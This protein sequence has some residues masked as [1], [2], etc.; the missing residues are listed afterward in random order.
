M[1]IKPSLTKNESASDY[2][3][4]YWRLLDRYDFEGA[5]VFL[6]SIFEEEG[7]QRKKGK[8][9]DFHYE[10]DPN[11][12]KNLSTHFQE[13]NSAF[14]FA[15]PL[16][17][18]IE[19]ILENL[20]ESLTEDHLL[21]HRFKPFNGFLFK[22]SD[23]E[24]CN[25]VMDSVHFEPSEETTSSAFGLNHEMIWDEDSYPPE[26]SSDYYDFIY[27][28]KKGKYPISFRGKK[29]KGNDLHVHTKLLLFSKM[30]GE[31]V[32]ALFSEER[33][34]KIPKVFPF[35]VLID[36]QD[37]YDYKGKPFLLEVI[38]PIELE[39]LKE[40]PHFSIYE[41]VSRTGAAASPSEEFLFALAYLEEPDLKEYKSLLELVN[42]HPEWKELLLQAGKQSLQRTNTVIGKP[43]WKRP[44]VNDEITDSDLN[45]A[46]IQNPG[47]KELDLSAFWKKVQLYPSSYF[48]RFFWQLADLNPDLHLETAKDFQK[49]IFLNSPQPLED[50]YEKALP[51]IQ[52]F[53]YTLV[54][55]Y[56]GIPNKH[57][58]ELRIPFENSLH[59]L[60]ELPHPGFK[61]RA[62]EI[63]TRLTLDDWESKTSPIL[64]NATEEYIKQIIGLVRCMPE[65]FPWFGD[66][67]DFIF[68]DRLT[69]L[70]KQ[71]KVVV[72]VL[73]DV[74]ER[75]NS[76]HYN[77]DVTL[78][79]APVFYEIGAEDIHPL[80]HELHKRNEFYMED[81]YAKWSKQ[82]PA[83]RWER[84]AEV[85]ENSSD[86]LN[87]SSTWESLLYDSLPGFQLYYENIE[88]RND[89]NS[90]FYAFLQ[91]LKDKPS[92]LLQRFALFYLESKKKSAK[93]NEENFFS[94][95]AE[96]TEILTLLKP[97]ISFT[98]ELQEVLELGISAKAVEAFAKSKENTEEILKQTLQEL[99]KNAF[100]LFL[101]TKTI[102]SKY[103][104]KNAMEELKTILPILW[105][106][107]Y[108]LNKTFFLF[109]LQS[110]QDWSR[111]SLEEI[112]AFYEK[113][114]KLFEKH[115]YTD[116]KFAGQLSSFRMDLFSKVLEEE[117]SEIVLSEQEKFLKEKS[118]EFKTL[119][120]LDTLS[121][122]K[123]ISHLRPG[124]SSLN[125]I[126]VSKLIKNSKQF[127]SSIFQAL[128]WE[129]E[130]SAI[131]PYLKLFYQDPF[132]KEKLYDHP[133]FLDHLSYFI[134]NYKDVASK[135]LAKNLF[136][137]LKEKKNSKP[138]VKAV[139][140]LENE[141]IIHCFLSVYWAFQN[142]DRLKELE[143]LTDQ[144][145]LKTDS[146]KPEYVLIA[147]NLG[148]I[149]IQNGN[150]EKAKDIFQNL[151]SMD[152]SR[153]DYQKDESALDMEK[154]LGPDINEQY[155]TIFRKYFAMAKFNAACLYSRL[156]DASEAV[157]HLR[158]AVQIE[159]EVY[160]RKKIL[161]E[162][163]FS[164]ISE[165]QTYQE[166]LNSLN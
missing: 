30:I 128:E 153:F 105:N 40:N 143:E 57:R 101:K 35:Y 165:H 96:V 145:L 86:S 134:R 71:A 129:T 27:D 141:T 60:Q 114:N 81:F 43:D 121:P 19:R 163:D 120:T 125:L 89:R 88:K 21:K 131:F 95:I 47:L 137:L 94:I 31:I 12:I 93:K 146:R 106:E 135:E 84:F 112:Y 85:A 68:E 132:L 66:S 118:E 51:Y 13:M 28:L 155:A 119:A 29:V 100:L 56:L 17:S 70:G 22:M 130:E 110:H 142:E 133:L 72:P 98:Q 111:V 65:K 109:C 39:S 48:S 159:P 147:G 102:E 99:P 164:A 74:L 45:S 54:D 20:E 6:S 9:A 34:A 77:E 103:G 38:P 97:Q 104:L 144:I 154:I 24:F 2:D 113:A 11:S 58:E 37:C 122:E 78:N 4:E 49:E 15:E 115:F 124:N 123:I 107:D 83:N 148:V 166:F 161:A 127:E 117:Y 52:E 8:P 44:S 26:E 126:L 14:H 3:T 69:V 62:M 59:R 61:L 36:S 46:E 92:D 116:G 90:I 79:L 7:N 42:S 138:I 162:T 82:A 139:K 151:F 23:Y 55:S 63:R 5:F 136:I 76:D 75:Y 140:T 158:E 53:S 87:S 32:Q 157:V 67:W 10:E 80:I 108:V 156:E 25:A 64:K 91:A 41:S 160:N 33:F 150:L 73:T 1:I 152:W 16:P 149:H 18:R 50:L